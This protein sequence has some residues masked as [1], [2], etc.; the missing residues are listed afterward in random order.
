MGRKAVLGV[1]IRLGSMTSASAAEGAGSTDYVRHDGNGFLED[2]SGFPLSE[3]N[4]QLRAPSD[5]AALNGLLAGIMSLPKISGAAIVLDVGDGLKCRASRGEGAPPVGMQCYPENGLTGACLTTSEVQLCNNV[6]EDS[7]VDRQACQQLGVRSVLVVPIKDGSRI[8]GVLE[9]LSSETDAFDEQKVIFVR[10]FAERLISLSPESSSTSALNRHDR[11]NRNDGSEHP[12]SSF[13][14]TSSNNFGLQELLEAAYTIQLYQPASTF[15]NNLA[16]AHQVDRWNES[17][18]P[19][20]ASSADQ[21]CAALSPDSSTFGQEFPTENQYRSLTIGAI[22]LALLLGG[23]FLVHWEKASRLGREVQVSPTAEESAL[24]PMAGK[25][26]LVDRVPELHSSLAS[27]DAQYSLTTRHAA[28][29]SAPQTYAAAMTL[30]EVAARRGDAEAGWKVALGYLRGI[31]VVRDE[32]KAAEW[33]KRAANLGDPRAQTALSD[34]YF[35]GV[36]VRRDYV[37]AYTWAS[38]AAENEQAPDERV[39]IL[40][41]RMTTAQL[42]DANRR[43]AAWFAQKSKQ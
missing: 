2:I 43:I 11:G 18:V 35:T 7:R 19:N 39:K 28:G 34:L 8:K 10:S 3:R 23:Y 13:T 14:R 9:A 5:G 32:T 42:E 29:N 41:Q 37:R 25:P 4:S 15:E 24:A 26:A 12:A 40:R 33:F 30:F 17:G 27:S 36:G 38:I 6:D 22:L 20:C 1:K 16:F 21:I 31:G